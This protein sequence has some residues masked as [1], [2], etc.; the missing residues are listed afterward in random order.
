MATSPPI[1]DFTI[2]PAQ[3]LAGMGANTIAHCGLP[4]PGWA[5]RH[6]FY[7]IVYIAR[8]RG[9]HVIDCK[10]YPLRPASLYFV[11]PDQVHAWVYQTLPVGYTLSLSEQV[12]RAKTQPDSG[13]HNLGLFEDLADAGQLELSPGQARS[14]RSVFEEIVSEYEDGRTGYSSVMHAYLHVL[15]TRA[16]RVLG[17][18]GPD[19]RELCSSRPLARRFTDLVT[20]SG[21]R[22]QRVHEYSERLGVTPSHLA[23]SVREVTGRTPGQIIRSA[24]IAEAS[25]LLRYTDKTIG[26]IAYDLGFK[27]AAYFGRFFKREMG[28]TPG[29]FRREMLTITL[30]AVHTAEAAPALAK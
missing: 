7:M 30:G 21:G 14:I 13:V 17:D 18:R 12:L 4:E 27:D 10:R 1:A 25:R 26:E 28:M 22:T 6:T 15:L 11:R 3:H 19:M 20:R 2:P 8:G 29:E 24:Q 9:E 16:H 5:H 23:E